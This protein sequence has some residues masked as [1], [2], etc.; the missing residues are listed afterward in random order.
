MK[1]VLKAL[2]LILGGTISIQAF[3]LLDAGSAYERL[4]I[5]FERAHKPAL[6]E[7]L[8]DSIWYCSG[9]LE[10]AKGQLRY[11]PFWEARYRFTQP[12]QQTLSNTLDPNNNWFEEGEEAVHGITVVSD[13]LRYYEFLRIN[14]SGDLIIEMA[15][16]ESYAR[17][18]TQRKRLPKA[19]SSD[20]LRAHQYI[21][22]ENPT[23][24]DERQWGDEPF[25]RGNKKRAQDQ[26]SF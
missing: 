1:S 22:C 17:Q 10:A 16:G 23:R 5:Q 11:V 9:S 20:A 7:L 15:T 25:D 12:D 4:R 13:N 8:T 21:F 3:G 18:V 26:G 6:K 24:H 14:D 2:C 19:L